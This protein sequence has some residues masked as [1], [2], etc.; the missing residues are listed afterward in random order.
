MKVAVTDSGFADLQVERDV[1]AGLDVEFTAAQCTTEEELIDQ[2]S[3]MDYLISQY[4]P[5][6]ARVIDKFD[7]CRV[8]S[9]YGV[10]VD[11]IDLDA[12][13]AAGIAVCNVPDYCIDEVADHALALLL[14]LTRRIFPA[15]LDVRAGGWK[16][17][18]ADVSEVKVLKELT[19]GLFGCGRIGNAVAKRLMGFGCRVLAYDPYVDDDQLNSSGV[20]ATGLEELLAESDVVSLHCPSNAETRGIVNAEMFG[21][22]KPGSLLVNV[23]RGD[24]VVTE[25]L[26]QVIQSGH[27]AGA[28]L[29]VTSPEPLP[30]GHP[31]A[32]LENV[33]ITP[34]FAAASKKAIFEL[35]RRTA[36][37][38]A[39][40]IRGEKLANIVNGVDGPRQL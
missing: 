4:A 20:Q 12:A 26:I 21:K 31:L 10:G 17:P 9:R 38:I 29:D 18:A 32:A 8:I 15:A 28:G 24:I 7:R 25:D 2:L 39:A 14:D 16:F 13:A 3:E 5:I 40:A 11:N 35:R 1:L 34:H 33:V 37:A 6:T 19:V 22:M 30:A 36:G 23:S 27:L